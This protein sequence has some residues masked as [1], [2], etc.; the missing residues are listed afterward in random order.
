MIMVCYVLAFND[1]NI[2]LEQRVNNQ[3]IFKLFNDTD[4]ISNIR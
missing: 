3:I 1:P 2:N 4:Y